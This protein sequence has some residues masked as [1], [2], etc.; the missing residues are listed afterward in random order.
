MLGSHSE[1]FLGCFTNLFLGKKLC[2]LFAV[3]LCV[4]VR[5]GDRKGAEKETWLKK[6]VESFTKLIDF[7][8]YINVFLFPINILLYLRTHSL[9]KEKL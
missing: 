1:A 2:V 6:L 8:V 3:M 9:S 7:L 5:I 4:V